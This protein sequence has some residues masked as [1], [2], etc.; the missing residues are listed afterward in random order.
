MK[1]YLVLSTAALLLSICAVKAQ[2][3]MQE[4]ESV[5]TVEEAAPQ[6]G[7]SMAEIMTA[8]AAASPEELWEQANELYKNGQ[9]GAAAELYEQIARKGLSSDKL[10]FNLANACFRTGKNAKAILYYNRAL[11]LN[12][13][14]EDIRYNLAVAESMN[15]DNIKEVPEFFLKSWARSIRNCFSEST[16]TILSLM[17]FAATLALL[18]T[19]RL[20]RRKGARKG[21]FFGMIATALL[22]IAA[23][24]FALS[25]RSAMLN[26]DHAIVMSSAV[27][28]KSSPDRSAT[29]LFVLHE[30]TK[31][32]ILNTVDRWSEVVIADGKKGWVESDKIE[33]I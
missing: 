24:S 8:A 18:A 4:P 1:R 9:F 5:A 14:D 22:C 11:L 30:G 10:W 31:V 6:D 29:D 21:A 15:K 26:R 7:G 27:P 33:V 13:G 3:P 25:Q 20:A 32:Q 16:W 28:V 23:T 12:P 17:A 19:F 2:T